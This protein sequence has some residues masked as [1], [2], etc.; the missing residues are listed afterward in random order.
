MARPTDLDTFVFAKLPPQ[1]QEHVQQLPTLPDVPVGG[2]GD[3]PAVQS[4]EPALD[5]LSNLP[6]QANLPEFFFDLF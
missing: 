3:L 2:A 6:E 1:A 4:H 5:A